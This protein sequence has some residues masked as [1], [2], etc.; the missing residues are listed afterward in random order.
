MKMYKTK[1]VQ[2]NTNEVNYIPISL[3]NGSTK[4]Y[5]DLDN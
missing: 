5:S 2:I 3:H 1:N 4:V